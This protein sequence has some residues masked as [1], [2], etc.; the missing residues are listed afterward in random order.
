MPFVSSTST[1]APNRS[2]HV[3]LT[4]ARGKGPAGVSRDPVTH[5][6]AVIG[7]H[8]PQQHPTLLPQHSFIAR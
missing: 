8:V 4:A 2:R 6:A 5:A 1:Q 3:Q 7:T